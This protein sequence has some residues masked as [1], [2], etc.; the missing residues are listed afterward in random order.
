MSHLSEE[1]TV[2]NV[3]E[4]YEALSLK[5][6]INELTES[7]SEIC[8]YSYEH[9][10]KVYNIAITKDGNTAFAGCE[11]SSILVISL[12]GFYLEQILN[13]HTKDIIGLKLNSDDAFLVSASFDGIIKSWDAVNRKEQNFIDISP[14]APETFVISLCGKFVYIGSNDKNVLVWE[15]EYKKIS[16]MISHT[17]FI[18]SLALFDDLNLLVSASKDNTIKIWNL[19]TRECQTTF[20]GHT[21]W[22]SC[23]AIAYN[24][25]LAISGSEDKTIKVWD[26]ENS[27]EVCCFKGH[28][29]EIYC[30]TVNQDETLVAS[31]AQDK[32]VKIWCLKTYTLLYTNNDH[33]TYISD[34]AFHNIKY[35]ISCS[36]NQVIVHNIITCNKMLCLEGHTSFINSV[37]SIPGTKK[38]I[39]VSSDHYVKVWDLDDTEVKATLCGHKLYVSCLEISKDHQLIVSGS[40]DKTLIVW[41][42]KEKCQ[43]FVLRGH[44]HYIS[45]L[46]ICNNSKRALSG[47]WDKT[48]RVWDLINGIEIACL[49]EHTGIIFHLV[50]DQYSK[51]AFSVCSENIVRCWSLKKLTQ[52]FFIKFDKVVSNLIITKDNKYLIT[53]CFDGTIIFTNIKT[54]L[55][56]RKFNFDSNILNLAIS[57]DYEIMCF[58]FQDGT[59]NVMNAN[60][61]TML[62]R[63][64]ADVK[65]LGG[66]LLSENKKY[67]IISGCKTELMVINL[68][69]INEHCSFDCESNI[70]TVILTPNI[71]IVIT[72]DEKGLI[73]VWNMLEKCLELTL[74][75]HTADVEVLCLDMNYG[76]LISGSKDFTVKIWFIKEIYNIISLKKNSRFSTEIY[77]GDNFDNKHAKYVIKPSREIQELRY[78]HHIYPSLIYNGFCQRLIKKLHPEPNDCRLLFPNCVNLNHIYSYLG[79]YEE[80]DKALRLGCNIRRDALGHSPLFYAL[81]KDSKRC[82]DVLLQFMIELS[83]DTNRY[84]TYIQYNYALRDDLLEV[85]KLPSNLVFNYIETLFIISK[86]KD[87][88]NNLKSFKPPVLIT[89]NHTKIYLEKFQL[90]CQGIKNP[91]KQDYFVEFRTTPMKINISN[92]SPQC[93][94]LLLS[95]SQSKN[96]KIFT[97]KLM[98][99][100]IDYKMNEFRLLILI[101]TSILWLNLTFMILSMIIYPESLIINACYAFIN[102]L[103]ALHE[104]IDLFYEGLYIYITSWRNY[105]DMSSLIISFIWIFNNIYPNFDSSLLLGFMVLINFIKGLNG[106]RA[107]DSTRFYIKLLLSAVIDAFPFLLICAYSTLAFGALYAVSAES[108]KPIFY[109]L[110]GASY[111]LNLGVFQV[112]SEF[113]INYL[114]FVIASTI[115][116][117]MMLNLLISIIGESFK[118]FKIEAEEIDYKEKLCLILELE[119]IHLVLRRRKMKGF[120]QLCEVASQKADEEKLIEKMIDF[121]VKLDK[122][123]G[124][125]HDRVDV[126]ADEIKKSKI[127]Y[128]KLE[129]EV[130]KMR[131]ELT[132]KIDAIMKSLRIT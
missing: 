82:I 115:D 118:N 94:K 109:L 76:Y 56:E 35:L 27:T 18:N 48:I 64:K 32:L 2:T 25:K 13:G 26:I 105:L 10:A 89:T 95:L 74:Y 117:V 106:F 131:E 47:S 45:C 22:V 112:K 9:S 85:I 128:E 33:T 108:D 62:G 103:L 7:N 55:T 65:F 71:N 72:G 88:P 34:L 79:Q 121:E 99:I 66:F 83:R 6:I 123:S 78:I 67:L 113:S 28:E 23:L 50:Q 59:L 41:S 107:F 24:K 52:K 4:T 132:L 11:D 104:I 77:D 44:E 58:T 70:K 5:S 130:V 42:I 93:F 40:W 102:L 46:I 61:N 127:A 36:Y 57:D 75:G 122:V 86:D 15:R 63:L 3:A 90:K 17:N 73:K 81:K 126:L 49:S 60:K 87:L 129:N 21:S 1:C 12:S 96:K 30:L 54:H 119:C 116:V 37:K 91:K 31:G 19:D 43:K 84:Q 51:C 98:K 101:I 92:G 97:S 29:S 111:E 125:V 14:L 124:N 53:P 110:W 100:I 16:Y 20:V 80:L 8:L 120:L 69:K 39:T 68:H 114:Y 38:I